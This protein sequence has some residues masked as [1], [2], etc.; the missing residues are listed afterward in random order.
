[1]QVPVKRTTR[2]KHIFRPLKNRSR[3][4]ESCAINS[5]L[6]YSVAVS[7]TGSQ[8]PA[9]SP[10]TGENRIPSGDIS[11]Y[12]RSYSALITYFFPCH[13]LC[14]R[15]RSRR[16]N[17]EPPHRLEL[18][19]DSKENKPGISPLLLLPK[20]FRIFRTSC[21]VSQWGILFDKTPEYSE[22]LP[23]LRL[24]CIRS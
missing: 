10:S 15:F 18:R 7:R 2:V 5:L 22:Y 14:S 13:P 4:A 12:A 8:F 9:F 16:L 24:R 6:L 1:M 19:E 23:L 21:L 17:N 11:I 3:M 20:K